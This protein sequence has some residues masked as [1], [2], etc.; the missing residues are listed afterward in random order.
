MTAGDYTSDH[1]KERLVGLIAKMGEAWDNDPRVSCVEMGMIGKWGEQHSPSPSLE[2]QQLLGTEFLKAFKNKKVMVRYFYHFTDFSFGY[3]W[4][5]FGHLDE[6]NQ[7][8]GMAS[9]GTYWK[10]NVN[11]GETAFD[12]G[13]YL[14]Q[15]GKNP[16]E[17]LG[18]KE[19]LGH[20]IDC[21]RIIHTNHL[22]WIGAYDRNDSMAVAGA[23]EFQK[24][25]GY[26]FVINKV[27][28]TPQIDNIAN[29]SLRVVMD[30]TNVGST[31]L[32]DKYPL[33][34]SLISQD[35][36]NK[37]WSAVC[38]DVDCRTWMPGD[39]WNKTSREY[40]LKPTVNI[41]DESFDIHAPNGE[42]LL[43]VTLLDPY[44][45]KPAARFAV[46]NYFAGGYTLLGRV[47]VGSQGT[48]YSLKGIVFD[49]IEA[50]KLIP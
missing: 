38:K 18:K 11:G 28:F 30:I 14:I 5:S 16:T 41:V 3:H 27:S 45:L 1:F 25:L 37:V 9:R 2:M 46:D 42:Y 29:H 17:A 24:V 43:A 12:W 31:P 34:I 10:N 26:R 50:E 4:D 39:A 40:D 21:A 33:E 35:T 13:N 47:Y 44:T 49:N 15:P 23:K 48:D 8:E 19:H 22:G 36:K 20:L 6:A 32:Y 7:I